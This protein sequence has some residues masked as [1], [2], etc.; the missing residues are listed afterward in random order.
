[1]F[2][3]FNLELTFR[4]FLDGWMLYNHRSRYDDINVIFELKHEISLRVK[5]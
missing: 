3:M 4:V 2:T 5:A 1:M